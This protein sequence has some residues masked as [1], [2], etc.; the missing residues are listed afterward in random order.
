MADIAMLMAEE[1]EKMM[2][3]MSSDHEDLELLSSSTVV[4]GMWLKRPRLNKLVHEPKSKIGLATINE[5]LFL[6]YSVGN[7][8]FKPIKKLVLKL[9]Q[10]IW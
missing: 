7:V 3:K 2:K 9:S 8:E 4:S 10:Q 5:Q 1:Y 6:R